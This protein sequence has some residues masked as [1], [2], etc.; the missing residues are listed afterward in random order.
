MRQRFTERAVIIPSGDL[1]LE[2]LWQKGAGGVP[3]TIGSPHPRF[4]GSMDSPVVSELAHGLVTQGAPTIRFNYRGVGASQ[5]QTE[6]GAGEVEDYLAA[7]RHLRHGSEAASYC[8]AGYSF[9]AWTAL[10][11]SLRDPQVALLILIAPANKT[12]D[13]DGLSELR[14]RPVLVIVGDNDDYADVSALEKLLETNPTATVERIPHADHFFSRGLVSMS[15]VA[16]D[17][18]SD[19]TGT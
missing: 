15:R 1:V 18:Y 10:A 2:G 17:W 7:A 3:V 16:A 8:A 4:G 6:A 14:N 13:F 5:G 9:G 19:R 12:L 11:A